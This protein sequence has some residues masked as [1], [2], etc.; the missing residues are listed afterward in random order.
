MEDT[1]LM[2]K[3]VTL[4]FPAIFYSYSV[5]ARLAVHTYC[6]CDV[7]AIILQRNVGITKKYTEI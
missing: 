3:T 7:D 5:V 6:G 4:P 2:W 1:K